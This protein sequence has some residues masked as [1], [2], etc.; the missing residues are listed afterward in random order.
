M[1]FSTRTEDFR[2]LFD[3]FFVIIFI[4]YKYNLIEKKKKHC[5]PKEISRPIY[6]IV[7]K[8]LLQELWPINWSRIKILCRV[9]PIWDHYTR[10]ENA[11]SFSNLTPS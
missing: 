2:S 11:R 5:E 3:Q 1:G 10:D 7:Q 9:T 4:D 6:F 8:S